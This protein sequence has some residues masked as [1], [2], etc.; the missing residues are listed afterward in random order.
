MS[1]P[2]GF[3]CAFATLTSVVAQPFNAD[4]YTTGK[5]SCASV[6]PMRSKSSK[7]WLTTHSGRASAVTIWRAQAFSSARVA[8]AAS[9]TS[10]SWSSGYTYASTMGVPVYDRTHSRQS[11]RLPDAGRSTAGVGAA[12]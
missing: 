6:A 12:V 3:E 4:A 8:W 11:A 2:S 9:S 5:S 7:V 10:S 1:A